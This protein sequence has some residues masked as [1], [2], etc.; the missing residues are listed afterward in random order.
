MVCCLQVVF[1]T[2]FNQVS[3]FVYSPVFGLSLPLLLLNCLPLYAQ[4]ASEATSLFQ[5][6]QRKYSDLPR[7]AADFARAGELKPSLRAALEQQIGKTK[8]LRV[9]LRQEK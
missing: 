8:A 6:A 3:R 5:R 9:K 7:A 1:P 2:R 4:E